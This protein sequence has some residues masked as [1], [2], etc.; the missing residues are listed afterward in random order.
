MQVHQ[1]TSAERG[2]N[3]TMLPFINAAGKLFPGV[4]VFPRKNVNHKMALNMPEGFIA[5]A[6]T[7]G[8]MTE[9]TFL[10]ALKH[11]HSQV[12][13]TKENPIL[14]FLDNHVSHMGYSICVFAKEN[15]IVLQTLP[16]HTSHASQPL[17][18]T[19]YKPFKCHLAESHSDWMR[20]H[21]GQ[22][23]SIY[24]VPLL[25]KPAIAHAFTEHNIKKGFKATG[26]YP[27]DR[28]AIPDS[29]FAPSAVTGLPGMQVFQV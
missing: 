22:R 28:N 6:H 21:P 29:M 11:L 24:E 25:S 20:D 18:R 4:F 3:V 1:M 13:S 5:V 12:K 23:I 8:W 14:L 7:S 15:G 16:P 26:L 17:D 19:V 2:V 27:F 9:E 10:T